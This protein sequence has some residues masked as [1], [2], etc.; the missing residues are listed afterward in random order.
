MGFP[1]WSASRAVGV[2]G[3]LWMRGR[4]YSGLAR[5]VFSRDPGLLED[6]PAVLFPPDE[7]GGGGYVVAESLPVYFFAP[8]PSYW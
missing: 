2:G 6:G 3:W 4:G 1:P 8:G 7:Y 5:Q